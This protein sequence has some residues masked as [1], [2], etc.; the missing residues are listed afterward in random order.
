MD[1]RDEHASPVAGARQQ[2]TAV[3]ARLRCTPAEAV[4]VCVLV[5]GA[6]AGLGLL[7]VLASP[8]LP[9]S[10]SPPAVESLVGSAGV[11]DDSLAP[12]DGQVS[13]DP[14]PAGNAGAPAVPGGAGD[15]PAGAQPGGASPPAELVVHV[16]G[17]VGVP[18]VYR[19]PAGSRV[20]EAVERAGGVL[21]DADVDALNLARAL[22]DGEQVRV[23]A[24]G[25]QLAP[26]AAAG[27]GSAAPQRPDGTL[28]LNLAVLDDLDELPGVGPV[29]AQRILDHR[30][31]IGRFT[32]VEELR[33]VKGIGEATFADLAPEVSV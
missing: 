12:G 20:A 3:A 1:V 19:L 21:G 8:R 24:V 6:V 25:E 13:G 9:G 26:T 27:S 4:A 16:A 22:V 31:E 32:T 7:W 30:A 11:P 2:L 18:G 10:P 28:D 29:L 17:R 15:G 5:A 33:D 23:P 14:L